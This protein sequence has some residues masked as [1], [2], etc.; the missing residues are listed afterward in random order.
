MPSLA[1]LPQILKAFGMRN[2]KQTHDECTCSP[3]ARPMDHSTLLQQ[4]EIL[5]TFTDRCAP[6]PWQNTKNLGTQALKQTSW[7]T[8][9]TMIWLTRRTHAFTQPGQL[10]FYVQTLQT[11]TLRVR[12]WFLAT[13]FGKACFVVGAII[14]V[15]FIK[16]LEWQSDQNNEEQRDRR[17]LVPVQ[18]VGDGEREEP[19]EIRKF[20][21]EQD[22]F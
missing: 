7:L 10:R 17:I 13:S 11:S 18:E 5:K 8:V 12:K 20:P 16:I 1:N 9:K 2:F 19:M 15:I 4:P 22:D 14:T 6:S 3:R 21:R